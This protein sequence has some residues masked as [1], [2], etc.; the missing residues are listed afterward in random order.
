MKVAIGSR[1]PV[2]VS[3][4]RK[5][6]EKYFKEIEVVFDE[7]NSEVGTQPINGQTVK[8]A[9]NRARKIQQKFDADYGVGVEGGMIELEGRWYNSACCAIVD[10][11]GKTHTAYGPFFE[12]SDKIMNEIRKGKELG[13]V[14][15]E[16]FGTKNIKQ[17]EGTIG[18]LSK[19]TITR[20]DGLYTSALCAL[21]P[22]L[23]E[24]HYSKD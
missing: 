8:G 20:E 9:I 17:K 21:I 24:E 7:V 5:A 19:N 10:R 1:N 22:F 15:D 6:F 18:L 2:K 14:T 12:I 13:P 23:N 4:V 16:L 11:K 3:A